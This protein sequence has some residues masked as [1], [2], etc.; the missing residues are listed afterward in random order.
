MKTV[1]ACL[2]GI[3]AW[4][5][6]IL[7]SYLVVIF[8]IAALVNLSRSAGECSLFPSGGCAITAM[9]KQHP[10]VPSREFP[11]SLLGPDG[12]STCRP[13]IRNLKI[14]VSISTIISESLV[15]THVGRQD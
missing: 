14:H 1:H 4:I 2:L 11:V 5:I 10:Y 6:I 8:L 3:R 15:P 7:V 13:R 12:A 9:F